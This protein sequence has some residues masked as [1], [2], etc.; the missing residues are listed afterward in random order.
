MREEA[1]DPA[2]LPAGVSHEETAVHPGTVAQP[3]PAGTVAVLVVTPGRGP[4]AGLGAGTEHQSK[5]VPT[6][7]DAVGIIFVLL[8]KEKMCAKQAATSVFPF[9][10]E[11]FSNICISLAGV[12]NKILHWPR[13]PRHREPCW[14][15]HRLKKEISFIQETN[16]SYHRLTSF[17]HSRTADFDQT[18]CLIEAAD[19][20]VSG[21]LVLLQHVGAAI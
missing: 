3:G 12:V 4:A 2:A 7:D 9:S 1:A 14:L 16:I 11:F 10:A 21:G 19:V 13:S 8:I 5:H 17:V 15:R 20:E 18:L 6:P